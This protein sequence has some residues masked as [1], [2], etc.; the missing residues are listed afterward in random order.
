M[1][2]PKRNRL[3]SSRHWNW[4]VPCLGEHEFVPRRVGCEQLQ[5][6]VFRGNSGQ[7]RQHDREMRA[8]ARVREHITN[9]S[10]GGEKPRE[11]KSRHLE[12]ESPHMWRTLSVLGLVWELLHV[13]PER[14][15]EGPWASAVLSDSTNVTHQGGWGAGDSYSASEGCFREC[16]ME[17]IFFNTAVWASCPWVSPQWQTPRWISC[18]S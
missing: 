12:E 10:Q 4:V 14:T 18:C 1:S 3:A 8:W 6:S 7:Q 17:E 15:Q 13:N 9:F 11:E 16:P 2:Q 5:G